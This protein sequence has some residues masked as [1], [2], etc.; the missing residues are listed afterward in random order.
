MNRL[1]STMR[2][3]IIV[4]FRNNLYAI[5]IGLSVIIAI[6]LSQ[7]AKPNQLEFAVPTLMILAIGGTTLMYVSG[8]IIFERDEGTINA[9]IVSPLTVSEYLWSKILSLTLLATLEAT[10]VIGGA[11]LI[12]SFRER[13]PMP[14]VPILLL[15]IFSIGIIYTLIGIILIVRY[16]K[17]T[18]FL[19]PMGGCAAVLQL[20]FLHFLG[21]YEHSAFLAVPTS[22]SAMLMRGAYVS[23][24]TGEWVYATVYT[25]LIIV[26]LTYWALHAFEKH[27]VAKVG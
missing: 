8:M 25:A 15:G 3:D 6:A 5:G 2:N 22:P 13:V 23:L 17:I 11:F 12:M 26:G 16:D 27:V 10:I 20:P 9:V 1:I 21:V 14:N 7:L 24:S 19:I 4:Q 18:D